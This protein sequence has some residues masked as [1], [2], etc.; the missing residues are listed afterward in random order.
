M[1]FFPENENY[2]SLDDD[3][4][5]FYKKRFNSSENKWFPFVKAGASMPWYSPITLFVNYYKDGYELKNFKDKKGNARAYIRNSD[6]YFRSGF[7]WTRRANRFYPYYIAPGCIPS[8]SRYMAYPF[9]GKEF[10]TVGFTASNIVSSI[11]RLYGEKFD[12]PNF[13]VE[14][15]KSLPF[16]DIKDNLAIELAKHAQEGLS[17][18]KNYFGSMEPYSDFYS[19][20]LNV[21]EEVDKSLLFNKFRLLDVAVD[22]SVS[23]SYMLDGEEV[24]LLTRDLIEALEQESSSS[25]EDSSEGEES[26]EAK[27][28]S[29]DAIISYAVGVAFGRWNILLCNKTLSNKYSG[30]LFLGEDGFLLTKNEFTRK[31]ENKYPVQINFSSVVGIDDFVTKVVDIILFIKTLTDDKNNFSENVSS[32]EFILNTL[33]RKNL[34]FEKHLACYSKSR[35]QA[36]IYWPLQTPS[37]SYTLWVYYHRL[38]EQTLYTCI[39]DFVEPKLAIV[40]ADLN[41][42][43]NKS[44]RSTEEEKELAQLIDLEAELKDFRDELLRLAKFWKPNLND[45]VQITAAPLWKLFQHKAWQKKL[46][47]TWNKLEDGEYDWAH[48]AGSVWPERVLRKCHQDRSLAIAHDVE[49]IFWHEVEIPIMRGKK[50]TGNTKIEWQPKALTESELTTLVKQTVIDSK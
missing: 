41:S 42:F 21:G 34:F 13:L 37:G 2:C 45:G 47:E 25:S 27:L 15:L 49:D 8:V 4:Y 10:S 44:A 35:R 6:F 20:I 7:S 28:D 30:G 50:P 32:S 9:P 23:E 33:S 12:R 11:M 39:N 31:Y 17:K 5:N 3:N 18:V 36:P 16:P 43:R 24:N 14:N 40:I 46:K 19:P 1:L 22:Q 26:L 29:D 48:L 38:N